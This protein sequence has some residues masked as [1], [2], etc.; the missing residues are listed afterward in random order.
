MK[1]FV[2]AIDQGTSSTR[3]ILYDQHGASLLSHQVPLP[4]ITPKPGY[5]LDQ[6]S[7]P[8]ATRSVSGSGSL[9]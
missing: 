5:V 1:R 4:L 8:E 9:K 2:A 7:S 3:V 6:V